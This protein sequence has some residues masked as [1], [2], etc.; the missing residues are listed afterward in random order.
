MT[1]DIGALPD[2][3]LRP[4][5]TVELI[6]PHQSLDDVAR[7]AGTIAYE[8]LT[9]LGQRYARIHVDDDSVSPSLPGRP[10]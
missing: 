4:G 9:S 5:D 3:A 1:L 7:D 2:G 6:G 8:I 10:A